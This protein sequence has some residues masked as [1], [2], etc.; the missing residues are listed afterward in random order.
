MIMESKLRNTF[1]R[2]S[3]V[4]TTLIAVVLCMAVSSLSAE[5][6][7]WKD[8]NGEVHYGAS[9]PAEY[10]EQPYDILNKSGLVI[11]HIEDTTIPMEV[12]EEIK[13][14]KKGRQPLISLEE[15]QAQSDKLLVIQ[16]GSEED[17]TKA[18]ELEVAQLGYDSRLI[19]QSSQSTNKAIRDQIRL[20]ADKQRSNQPVNEE[21]QK[22]IAGLY[23]R[24]AMDKKRLAAIEKREERI[25]ARFQKD[26]DRYRFLTTENQ[27]AEPEQVDQ[28]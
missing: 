9:V 7:R 25:R 13:A 16:Y 23:S 26:L 19:A 1:I 17:I 12:I 20:A 15:R 10:A 28:G 27:P 8:K 22:E 11:E 24:R 6:Y 2:P 21:Q 14:E 4:L 18:L 5:T 3:R